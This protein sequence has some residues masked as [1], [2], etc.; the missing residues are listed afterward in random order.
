MT[1]SAK[2]SITTFSATVNAA[3]EA[4]QM[5]G[6]SRSEID[7]AEVHDCFTITQIINIE[8]LVFFEKGQGARAVLS[9]QT[10]LGGRIPINTSGGLK[11]K[12][13]PIG[14]EVELKSK[15]ENGKPIYQ[16]INA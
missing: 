9:G 10:A 11:A 16:L 3:N 7:L 6:V 14:M 4:Y 13:H 1:I 8:D 12:G 15:D 5:A 2:S